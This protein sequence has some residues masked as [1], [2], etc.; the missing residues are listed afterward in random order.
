MSNF[1]YF[2]EITTSPV[3]STQQYTNPWSNDIEIQDQI[4]DGFKPCASFF[5]TKKAGET[6]G[7]KSQ[8]TPVESTAPDVNVGDLKNQQITDECCYDPEEAYTYFTSYSLPNKL[9]PDRFRNRHPSYYAKYLLEL[10]KVKY[11]PSYSEGEKQNLFKEIY[12]NDPEFSYLLKGNKPTIVCP[13]GK[14]I[15]KARKLL[16]C[17]IYEKQWRIQCVDPVSESFLN[18][19]IKV[20]LSTRFIRL[21]EPKF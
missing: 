12:N 4:S 1:S 10:V 11:D 21:I 15:Q 14:S 8:S 5:H 20:L 3:P 13:I 7:K 6:Y 16:M 2:S 17:K 9:I 18:D 19:V